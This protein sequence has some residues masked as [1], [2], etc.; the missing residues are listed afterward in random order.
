MRRALAR[1]KRAAGR[2]ALT[3][4]EESGCAQCAGGLRV[5]D[6][7][8]PPYDTLL[9]S[10][11]TRLLLRPSL[12]SED[13]AGACGGR[14]GCEAAPAVQPRNGAMEGWA[15]FFVALAPYLSTFYRI[16]KL[17]A[18]GAIA[19]IRLLVQDER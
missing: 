9:A 6:A 11:P 5:C 2:I 14:T 1:P 13:K 10:G 4:G 7:A 17:A 16:S 18:C 19:A 3:R 12:C 15:L 8:G